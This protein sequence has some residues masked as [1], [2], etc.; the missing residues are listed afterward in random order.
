M[1]NCYIPAR[2]GKQSICQLSMPIGSGN[3]ERPE[4][5]PARLLTLLNCRQRDI[6]ECV[7]HL[8]NA[9]RRCDAWRPLQSCRSNSFP[10][11]QNQI[12]ERLDD[13]RVARANG[14]ESVRKF[15]EW[16]HAPGNHDRLS[17][18]QVGRSLAL[19]KRSSPA[20]SGFE[21]RCVRSLQPLE[22]RVAQAG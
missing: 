18:S 3:T 17:Q 10:R 13:L 22:L 6:P 12:P 2:L 19:M 9:A 8:T 15:R 7:K 21:R 11:P 1:A 4:R 14:A 16:L 5:Q 20:C